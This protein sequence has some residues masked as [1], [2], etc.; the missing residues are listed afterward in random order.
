MKCTDNSRRRKMRVRRRRR[1]LL[2]RTMTV[3]LLGLCTAAGVLF[4]KGSTK[5]EHL[6]ADYEAGHYLSLIHI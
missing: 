1:Q 4:Y 3:V 6:A 5:E 2:I